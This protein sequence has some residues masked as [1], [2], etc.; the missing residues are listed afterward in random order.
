ME[1]GVIPALLFAIRYSPSVDRLQRA[2]FAKPPRPTGFWRARSL[3]RRRY[4][5]L[6]HRTTRRAGAIAGRP[7]LSCPVLKW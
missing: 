1:R 4:I 2:R 5:L 3:R 7:A 6:T